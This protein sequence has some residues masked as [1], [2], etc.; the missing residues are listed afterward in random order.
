VLAPRSLSEA[1]LGR[2]PVEA[3]GLSALGS[4]DGTPAH[5]FPVEQQL[6]HFPAQPEA[7]TAPR[8]RITAAPAPRLAPR[9][10]GLA[11]AVTLGATAAPSTFL[12]RSTP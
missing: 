5:L 11:T 12:L 1:V 7:T 9:T 4:T 2:L 3:E 6:R 8:T 10:P